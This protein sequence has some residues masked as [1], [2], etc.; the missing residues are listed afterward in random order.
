[1]LLKQ[2]DH[3]CELD[4]DVSLREHLDVVDDKEDGVFAQIGEEVTQFLDR[5]GGRVRMLR[6]VGRVLK[7]GGDYH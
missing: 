7:L 2:L 6:E 5:K 3:L 4:S 1:M